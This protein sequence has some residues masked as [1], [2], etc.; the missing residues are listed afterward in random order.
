M[1]D[2]SI[3]A[4]HA[5]IAV[6]TSILLLVS[7]AHAATPRTLVAMVE[8]VSHGDT[9]T[10]VTSNQTKLRIRILGID[11]PEIP[12]GKKPGRPF[13]EDARDYLT[14]LIGCRTIRVETYG[15]D[16]YKRILAV[17]FL[18]PTS[19]NV[20]MVE[21]GLAEL[22]RSAPCKACCRDLRVAEVQAKQDRVGMWA[23]G[24]SYKSPTVFRRGWG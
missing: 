21:L 24:A 11:A 18:A 6:A 4:R 16:R 19:V 22:Y 7:S 9:I 2:A 15:P 23:Q 10:A 8:R 20:E 5:F 12:H 13:G 14:R 17:V 3:S 1:A